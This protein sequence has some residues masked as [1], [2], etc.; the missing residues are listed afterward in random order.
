MKRTLQQLF[1]CA[2]AILLL[3][4]LA[5]IGADP[6]P[7][8]LPLS[9]KRA[10]EIATSPK[11]NANIVLSAEAIRQAQARS[12][13]ERA[14]FLPDIEGA[15]DQTSVIKSLGALG[16]SE[17]PL[18]FGLRIPEIIGPY[19]VVDIR[20]SGTETF[21]FSSIRRYQASRAGVKTARAERDNTENAV[22][23]SV[24]RD[25]MQALRT[26]EDFEAARADV[27]LAE[28]LE[29]QA[30][31]QKAFG[32]GT[33]IEVTRARAQ[34]SNERQREL[35][36]ENDRRRAR[37]ELLRAIGMPLETDFALTSRLAYAPSPEMTVE[38]AIARA[39]SSRADLRAQRGHENAARLNASGAKWDRLPAV[40]GYGDYG[41]TGEGPGT[42]TLPTREFGIAVKV[43]A[44]DGGRT[45]ARR[46]ETASEYR[47]E[48][49]RTSDLQRQIELEVR[50]ALDSLHAA[51][52]EI[53]VSE[54]GLTLAQGEL[55][56]ARRR[57]EAGVTTGVEVT[58]A[59]TRMER[60]RANRIAALF[61]YNLARID[62]GQAMGTVKDM[63]E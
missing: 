50:E 8:K 54:E 19:D 18:P 9:I 59:Q 22:A 45:D 5:A 13:E 39:L 36:A 16:L 33:G 56:Q 49:V 62:L 51:E 42:P 7:A 52:Q 35:V 11:G 21:A 41:T 6:E 26:E 25:Y 15:A 4:P 31:N 29:R 20:A 44:F 48:K 34:L 17:I 23:A 46:A 61:N 2:A 37:L 63:V 1:S 14:A 32:T 43:N 30:E 28:A 3:A 57:Y 12:N 38:D 47:G 40:S 53:R 27:T 10:V 24:A 55:E 58:D 60:A